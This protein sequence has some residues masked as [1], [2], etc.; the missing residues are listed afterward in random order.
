MNDL[1]A[2]VAVTARMEPIAR[3]LRTAACALLLALGAACGMEP[4]QVDGPSFVDITWMSMANVHYQIGDAG[5][6][7]DGYFTRIPR[8]DFFGG[9]GGLEQTVRPHVPDVDAVARVLAALGGATRIN[10]LLT[11]HSHFDHSFDIATWSRLTGAPIY[12]SRTTCFQA[13]A[14]NVP[15]DRCTPVLGGERIEIVPNVAMFVVRWNHSGDPATNPE[16]H[17]PVEL[18]AV[19]VPDPE[20]GGLRAG[21][22]EDFPNGGGSRGYLFRVD[23]PEG[24]FSWFYQSTA[25]AVD[26]HLPV[27]V[28][29]IDYGVP[30]DN[31]AAAMEQAGL[32]SVD[33]WVGRGDARVTQLVLP[34]L[35]PR[36]YL[37]IH[38]DGLDAPFE[39]GMP[40]AFFEPQLEEVLAAAGVMVIRPGQYMDKWRLDHEGVRPIENRAVKQALGFAAVQEFR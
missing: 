23:G 26:L 40:F 35:A 16:Q 37:P 18:D 27:V 33:L 13:I 9:G 8:S 29:D 28:D 5:V 31:L 14:G 4:A 39:S 22:A 24:S 36:A 32:D 17:N 10:L 15:E 11:G 3:R 12:G 20:T 7:T 1:Q 30:L 19:P 25:S 2:S 38:W 34:I 6:V 21:V